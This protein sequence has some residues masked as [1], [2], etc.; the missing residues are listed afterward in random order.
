MRKRSIK[1][2]KNKI[3]RERGKKGGAGGAGRR[4][5]LTHF[6]SIDSLSFLSNL[7][8]CE[9]HTSSIFNRHSETENRKMN[10][11]KKRKSRF[12]IPPAP[13]PASEGGQFLSVPQGDMMATLSTTPTSSDFLTFGQKFGQ[14]GT[15]GSQFQPQSFAS[16]SFSPFTM[17]SAGGLGMTIP[18]RDPQEELF[19][20]KLRKALQRNFDYL[21]RSGV[22]P[23][24]LPL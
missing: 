8:H 1:I 15:N 6:Q 22:T 19:K 2:E 11:E 24:P 7:R 4:R 12:D 20:E 17:L 18:Q 16:F 23:D 10:V 9:P 5:G 21:R 13:Y 14:D 3:G